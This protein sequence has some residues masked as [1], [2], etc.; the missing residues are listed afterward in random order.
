[1]QCDQSSVSTG[2]EMSFSLH[3][4]VSTYT[5]MAEYAITVSMQDVASGDCVT[6]YIGQPV[7]ACAALQPASSAYYAHIIINM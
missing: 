3:V 1:M 5:H 4:H 6:P 7:L 2:T